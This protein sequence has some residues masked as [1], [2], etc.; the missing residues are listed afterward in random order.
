MNYSGGG[1]NE[2]GGDRVRGGSTRYKKAEQDGDTA[3]LD[4]EV[5]R[6]RLHFSFS[7][8]VF[9]PVSIR[10][11]GGKIQNLIFVNNVVNFFPVSLV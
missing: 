1:G 9:I 11:F 4:E 6:H 3:G 2:R 8:S 10:K 7:F 5:S